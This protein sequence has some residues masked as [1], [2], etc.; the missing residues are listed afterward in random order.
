MW[1]NLFRLATSG[2]GRRRRH[3][4]NDTADPTLSLAAAI[5]MAD[6]Y[7]PLLVQTFLKC[8]FLTRNT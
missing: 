5:S 7:S 2:C 3:T 6:I 4:N 1:R 8:T